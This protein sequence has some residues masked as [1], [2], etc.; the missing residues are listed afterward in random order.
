M[1]RGDRWLE[2]LKNRVQVLVAAFIATAS[3]LESDTPRFWAEEHLIGYCQHPISD[4]PNRKQWEEFVR[5]AVKDVAWASGC[6]E[7]AR[8]VGTALK[9]TNV[10][11]QRA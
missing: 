4:L 7:L 9:E 8:V 3:C 6:R 10:E 5:D 11:P 1:T 2:Q